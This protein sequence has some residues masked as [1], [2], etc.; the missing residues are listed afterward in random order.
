MKRILALVL[1]FVLVS[2]LGAAA[3]DDRDPIVGIWHRYLTTSSGTIGLAVL[4]VDDAGNIYETMATIN[5]SGASQKE[6]TLHG[7]W[8]A[9]GGD[10]SITHNSKWDGQRNS[11]AYV[12]GNWL[13][14]EWTSG[15]Y[16]G[17]T[18]ATN[19]DPFTMIPTFDINN[20]ILT[21]GR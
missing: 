7:T 4:L 21:T 14:I 13:F 8:Q 19:D 2:A 20:V 11:T 16:T 12:R 18:R 1:A 3:A 17:F 9:D 5:S 15:F 10:Y 6:L